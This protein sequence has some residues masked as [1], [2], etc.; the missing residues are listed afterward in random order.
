M[1]VTNIH[2]RMLKQPSHRVSPLLSTLASGQEDLIMPHEKWPAMRLDRGLRVGSKGGHGPIRYIVRAYVPG[3]RI[4]F[5]FTGPKGFHGTHEFEIL[6]ISPTETC[7]RHTIEMITRGRGTLAWAVAIRWLHDAL[8]EDAFDNVEN[9]FT[10]EG[11]ST[12]WSPWVRF[13]RMVLR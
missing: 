7:M 2:E 1:K 6:A 4:R 12:P 3:E 11:K 8:V 13:L 5:E 10:N 9:Y